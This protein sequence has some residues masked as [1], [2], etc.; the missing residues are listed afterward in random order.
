VDA[1]LD[2]FLTMSEIAITITGFA[3]VVLVFGERGGR[4]VPEDSLRMFQLLTVSIST[5]ALCLIPFG[6]EVS[7]LT[8]E[9]IWSV[10]SGVGTLVWLT[11][12]LIYLRMLSRLTANQ[13]RNLL[14][15]TVMIRIITGYVSVLTILGILALGWNTFYGAQWVYFWGLLAGVVLS[16]SYLGFIVFIRPAE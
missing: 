16:A 11:L 1:V 15:V 12:A 7:G 2:S 10:S 3:G 4:L 8:S 9:V 13:L 5:M 14:G 6:L